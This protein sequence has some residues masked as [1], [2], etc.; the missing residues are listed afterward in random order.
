MS[1]IAWRKPAW[2]I[3]ISCTVLGPVE[4]AQAQYVRMQDG[5]QLV[6]RPSSSLQTP[7]H[8]FLNGFE[9]YHP[10]LVQV[11]LAML[12]RACMDYE[13][14]H[15]TLPAT[16][17]ELFTGGYVTEAWAF[18]NPGDGDA[19]PTTIDNDVPDA[20]NSAQVS[21]QYLGGP[22]LPWSAP[23][24][25]D[26]TSANNAGLM[27]IY[28]EYDGDWG[29]QPDPAHAFVPIELA[30]N[31]NTPVSLVRPPQAPAPYAFDLPSGTS[32]RTSASAA[33]YAMEAQASLTQSIFDV[34][35]AQ[36]AGVVN[37][38]GTNANGLVYFEDA[39]AT[40]P[41]AASVDGTIYATFAGRL[42]AQP[43]RA[44]CVA[45]LNGTVMVNGAPAAQT[46]ALIQGAFQA[47]LS[48]SSK[49]SIIEHHILQPPD[50]GYIAGAVT[51]DVRGVMQHTATFALDVPTDFGFLTTSAVGY[52][53]GTQV[54]AGQKARA[55]MVVDLPVNSG[56]NQLRLFMPAG[57]SIEVPDTAG[58]G[59][60]V[61]AGLRGDFDADG[62]VGASDRT[63]F[64]AAYTQP[65]SHP[66]H[67]F[68]EPAEL[69]VFD[70]DGDGD[71]DCRDYLQFKAA[72]TAGGAPAG[73]AACDLD[74]DGDGVANGDD[75]C[76]GSPTGGPVAP[77]G[78]PRGDL[79]ADG[80]IGSGD[81]AAFADCL[82]GEGYLPLP[83]SMTIARCIDTFDAD[84]DRDVDLADYA[85][86][87]R[88]LSE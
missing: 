27:R 7:A 83:G 4:A 82:G 46:L 30:L 5:M 78:C 43:G 88:S 69:R 21:F 34:F 20:A 56:N 13:I 76:P 31:A 55:E 8:W 15:G 77:T 11:R 12:H 36:G 49:I 54:E 45:A 57:Y 44:R 1:R 2:I 71:I 47:G 59:D 68:G 75:Q 26:N 37:S 70:F 73:F 53:W 60:M 62:S 16:A 10:N 84:A 22:G 42:S 66:N 65:L 48:A 18:H 41:A 38:A 9:Q 74:S 52:T 6:A 40:G 24:F 17:S 23:L 63:A 32:A 87:Q 39:V 72:W 61:A 33:H 29:I 80:A 3:G 79:D 35:D 85:A 58:P 50:S 67:A 19:E 86:L 14:A 28:V 51:L 81:F 25:I 64:A